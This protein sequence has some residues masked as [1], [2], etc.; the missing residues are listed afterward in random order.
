MTKKEEFEKALEEDNL[1]KINDFLEKSNNGCHGYKWLTPID[2]YYIYNY[3][4]R[5][6]PNEKIVE[7]LIKKGHFYINSVVF[8]RYKQTILHKAV[9]N[10]NI[11]AVK[12]LLK[13]NADIHEKD[14]FDRAPLQYADSNEMLEI[15][16]ENTSSD[17]IKKYLFRNFSYFCSD[18]NKIKS[19]FNEI[20]KKKYI[21]EYN[22]KNSNLFDLYE[23]LISKV[24]SQDIVKK[25]IFLKREFE[26]IEELELL[27]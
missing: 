15:M 22:Q 23:I 3:I 21:E 25:I 2:G 8:T 14:S 1:E 17:S 16:L 12:I 26:L 13:Y 7:V 10:N 6:D 11:K 9:E 27:K 18:D 4:R 5:D 19:F 20:Y 24:K